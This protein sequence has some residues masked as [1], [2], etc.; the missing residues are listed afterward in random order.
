[1][2]KQM[3][4]RMEVLTNKIINTLS[5]FTGVAVPKKNEKDQQAYNTLRDTFNAFDRDGSAEL[6]FEE[7]LESWKFLN[8]PGTDEEIKKTFDAIDIDGTGLVEWNEYAFSL[9]GE[10]AMNYGPLADL[11]TLDGLLQETDGVM[12]ELRG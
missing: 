6:G 11:E 8:R 5:E 12:S 10:K 4:E 9:M 2:K 7:Y 1:M 3:E